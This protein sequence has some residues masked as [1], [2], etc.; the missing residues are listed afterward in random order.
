MLSGSCP[1]LELS[2]VWCSAAPLL[3][4]RVVSGA[5]LLTGGVIECDIALR[6]SV[7]VSCILCKIR[8]NHLH[9]LYA[10][11]PVPCT[12]LRDFPQ[13]FHS[14]VSVTVERSCR[15]CIRWNG[16]GGFQEQSQCFFICLSCSLPFCLLQFS[17]SL[18]CFYWLVWWGWGLWTD[19]V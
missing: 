11:L 6:R 9:P 15:P 19:R 17:L 16:P 7:A 12:A 14:H 4:D 3:L 1:F 5:R 13:D 10:A 8:C 2:A 18:L